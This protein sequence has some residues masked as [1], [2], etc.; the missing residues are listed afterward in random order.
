VIK[1]EL[2]IKDKFKDKLTE[3]FIKFIDTLPNDIEELIKKTGIFNIELQLY[4]INSNREYI[5]KFNT[6]F[7]ED[8]TGEFHIEENTK[9]S[10]EF[11][12]NY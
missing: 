11:N 1:K 10:E 12:I 9:T 4:N 2:E 6:E 7:V 5:K 3:V 8:T